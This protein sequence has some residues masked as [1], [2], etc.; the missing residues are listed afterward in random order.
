MYDLSSQG[1]GNWLSYAM[2]KRNV[3]NKQ[4]ALEIGVDISAISKWRL[5][6]V[7]IAKR[8]LGKVCAA[9]GISIGWLIA[10]EGS[11]EQGKASLDVSYLIQLIKELIKQIVVV[12]AALGHILLALEKT[13]L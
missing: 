5:G 9:L 2:R 4:L 10:G 7:A 12:Q 11:M 8:N 6:K 1:Q 3:S 13:N